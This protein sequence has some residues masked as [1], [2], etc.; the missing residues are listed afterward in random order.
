MVSRRFQEVNVQ[1]FDDVEFY[2][3]FVNTASTLGESRQRANTSNRKCAISK[4]IGGEEE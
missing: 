3:H 4:A 1:L 2:E